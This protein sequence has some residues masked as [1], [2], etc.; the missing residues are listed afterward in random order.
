MSY[1]GWE[2]KR[3]NFFENTKWLLDESLPVSNLTKEDLD[4]K[5]AE[6]KRDTG[7][8]G[9]KDIYISADNKEVD[10]IFNKYRMKKHQ[11]IESELECYL[12]HVYKLDR[13]TLEKYYSV[14]NNVKIKGSNFYT[15]YYPLGKT[16]WYDGD[17]LLFAVD[18]SIEDNIYNF[19]I[20]RC[21]RK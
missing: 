20:K 6:Y 21:W 8:V 10:R 15:R 11:A 19:T 9:F 12:Q 16:E 1:K 18:S 4:V 14:C 7:T 17:N 2:Y 13:E 5:Y 3:D